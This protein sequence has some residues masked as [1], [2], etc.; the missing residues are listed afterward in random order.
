MQVEGDEGA[1]RWKYDH[2]HCDIR[3][4]DRDGGERGHE[5]FHDDMI[6]YKW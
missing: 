1:V 5:I 4:R 6:M 3:D 2:H